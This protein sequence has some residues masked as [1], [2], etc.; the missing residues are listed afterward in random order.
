MKNKRNMEIK[1]TNYKI[2]DD[3]LWAQIDKNWYLV[4]CSTF[5]LSSTSTSTSTSLI[6]SNLLKIKERKGDNVEG[7]N[8]LKIK[9][10]G[11]LKGVRMARKIEEHIGGGLRTQSIEWAIEEENRQIFTKWGTI[12]IKVSRGGAKER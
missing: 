7:E 10:S 12:G 8:G 5:P 11:R 3:Q 2:K 6:T 9:L 1:A 4:T